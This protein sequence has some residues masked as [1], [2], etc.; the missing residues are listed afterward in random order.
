MR[1]GIFSDTYHP[2]INGIVTSIK[3]L[4]TELIK[5]G[6]EVFIFCPSKHEKYN[7]ENV[8]MIK[9]VPLLIGKKFNYRLAFF[10]SKDIAKKIKSLNLDIIHT[11]TEFGIGFFGK[12]IAR[13]YGIP[14]IHTY[15]TLWESYLGYINP[16]SGGKSGYSKKFARFISRKFIRNSECVIAPSYET[17]K[18]LNI[19]CKVD[20]NIFVVPTGIEIDRFNPK[21][22]SKKDVISLKKSLGIKRSDKVVLF[23]GRVGEEKSIDKIIS[24]MKD[25]IKKIK[26]SKLVIV[27]GGPALDSLRKQS[28]DLGISD[29]VIFTGAVPWESV[30]LYYALGDV[31]VNASVTETQG[32]TFI[33]AFASGAAVVCKYA[34]NLSE[35]IRDEVNGILVKDDKEF[36]SSIIRVLNNKDLRKSLSAN[37]YIT[38]EE[39]SSLVFGKK[40]ILI[41]SEIIDLY[42]YKKNNKN[43]KLKDAYL[44]N[45]LNKLRSKILDINK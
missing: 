27:G 31:F 8:Y 45:S 2:D 23:I 25:T 6:H 10:Y 15:H 30:P 33:E 16:I 7:N 1:V 12:I 9:S 4:E 44:K 37:G 42:N 29:N 17:E 43:K 18:Y 36:A 13:K 38:A 26:N 24:A 28:V 35:V 22:I 39:S 14:F 20:E 34:P 41:Y 32:L 19:T 40:L 3:M 21:N 11:Q 5:Q